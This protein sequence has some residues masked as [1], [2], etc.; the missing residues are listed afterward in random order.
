MKWGIIMKST[1]FE[2]HHQAQPLIL[3]NWWD[4]M[5]AQVV[6]ERGA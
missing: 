1:F 4:V 2:A 3:H 6:S 5:S